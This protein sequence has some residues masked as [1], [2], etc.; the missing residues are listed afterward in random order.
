LSDTA[1]SGAGQPAP[2]S[3]SGPSVRLIDAFLDALWAERGISPATT[4]AYRQDLRGFLA[5][6]DTSLDLIG[7]AEVLAF[8]ARRMRSG[9]GTNSVVRQLSCLRQFFAWALRERHVAA[10]PMLDLEGP[11]KPRSL[12]GTLSAREVEALI[13]APAGDTPLDRRDRAILETLYAT[14]MRVSELVGVSLSRVNLGQG[15]IRV[16]GKGGRERLVPLGEAAIE[17]IGRW[18]R[19]RAELRPREDRLFVS[20]TGRPLSRQVVWSRIRHWAQ[21]AGIRE[22]VYPHRLRHSFATHLLDNGAD[23][24]VVQMLLGHADLSTTQVYTHVSRA[25][26]KSL[27]ERHHPRG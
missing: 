10:D 1:S 22:A 3:P 2:E 16:L 5:D 15:V 17:A 6:C 24:R 23:L 14:G 8:L 18:L 21:R 7:R 20:R 25:R 9:A 26:L 13:R 19:V 12:P 4:D 11:R 27:H